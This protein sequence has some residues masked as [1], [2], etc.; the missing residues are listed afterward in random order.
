MKVLHVI[1]QSLPNTAG[2]SI[3]SRDIIASQLRSGITPI[4]IT[5]PFQESLNLGSI[6]EKIEGVIYYRTTSN[7]KNEIVKEELT[8][9][10]TQIKKLFRIISFSYL[11][12]TIAKKEN[13]DVIHAHAMFFCAFSAKISSLF[14]GIPM[15]YEVRSLWEERYKDKGPFIK[16]IFEIVTLVE[17]L[18]MYLSD[19]IIVINKN[20]EKNLKARNLLQKK[21]VCV[22]SNAVNLENI[23]IINVPKRE[24]VFSYIGTLSP[25]EGL[26]LLIKA[27]NNLYSN[28]FK[29]KLLIYGNGIDKERLKL[30]AKNNPLVE[31]K[32]T[33]NQK[34][35]AHVYS[36]IDIV[37]NPRISNFLT[38]SVTPLKPLEAMAY[39]KLV[40][41]SNVGG[42]KEL[43]VDK[44][45]GFLFKSDSVKEI[46]KIIT[47]VLAEKD[48]NTII[49]NAHN[50]ILKNKSWD[51]NT[52]IYHKIYTDLIN[53]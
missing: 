49:K 42:M 2:S 9:F 31:F 46:E 24:I 13:I 3:R 29:N 52:K 6:K 39:M 16:F 21:R 4:V 45:T 10:F 36:T 5:S 23:K 15:I 32:G 41:A 30:L 14:L 26:D 44:K 28:N 17:S 34:E 48:F 20:L 53:G 51:E 33:F 38:N 50:Y 11:V 1:Y 8:S 19:Y 40:L 27:F 47:R 7:F 22:I 43:I 37:I 12:F 25:I 35:V 18:A